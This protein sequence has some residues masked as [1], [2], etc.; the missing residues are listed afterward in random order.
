[1]KESISSRF[2][3]QRKIIQV[4]KRYGNTGIKR[5]Q[6]ST[7][8]KYD[9]IALTATTQQLRFFEGAT[10][11]QFPFTNI[12]SEG[13]KLP[14]GSSM[15]VERAYLTILE[16]DPALGFTAI[17]QPDTQPNLACAEFGLMVANK[18]VIKNVPILSWIPEYNK[19]AGSVDYN[20]FEF[21]TQ[22]SLLPLLEY[23]A[24]IRFADVLVEPEGKYLR[25]TIEGT[26]AIIS[27]SSPF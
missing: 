11:R 22:V 19:S 2:T 23:I 13:N 24:T 17:T 5:Q 1:M 9:T 6:G 21:D 15:I 10:N 18:E 3:P 7:V 25:L 26:G 8:V 14:V 12:N 27:P 20:N 16:Y 4:N